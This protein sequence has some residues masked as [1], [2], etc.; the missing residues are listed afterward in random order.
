[1][2]NILTRIKEKVQAGNFIAS[3]HCLNALEDE[4]FEELDAIKAIQIALD[5]DKLTSDESHVRYCIYGRARD[6]R[7]LTIVVLIHQGTVIF[8][9]AYGDHS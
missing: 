5:F 7:S 3:D 8:K 6:G 2:A 9:T 1:M 4:G